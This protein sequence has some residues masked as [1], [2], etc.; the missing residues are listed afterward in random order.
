MKLNCGP[1]IEQKRLELRDR[2]CVW[3]RWFAWFP[4]RVSSG[5]CVW[6]EYVERRAG[7][8][9]SAGLIYELTPYDFTYRSISN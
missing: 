1:T 9:S 4:V 2:F 7:G 3:H 5:E 8:I 6:L